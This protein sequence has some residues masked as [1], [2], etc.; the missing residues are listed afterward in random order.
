[1][2][3]KN[4]GRKEYIEGGRAQGMN[5][6]DFDQDQLSKGEKV[7]MEH[8][9]DPR[10]AREIAMDHLAEFEDAPYYDYLADMERNIEEDIKK[11]IISSYMAVAS[12]PFK[13][14]QKVIAGLVKKHENQGESITSIILLLQREGVYVSRKD[15]PDK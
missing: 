2:F 14:R 7:Q 9:V 12:E 6:D 15:T 8:T 13:K 11:D 4:S 5:P 1:M 10:I 3:K